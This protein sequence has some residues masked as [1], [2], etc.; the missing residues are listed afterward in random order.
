M[1][2]NQL[3]LILQNMLLTPSSDFYMSS[4]FYS[5]DKQSLDSRIIEHINM[6]VF[7]I[8][9]SEISIEVYDVEVKGCSNAQVR[10][11]AQGAPDIIVDGNVVSFIATHP[12]TQDGYQRPPIRAR[13]DTR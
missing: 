13:A 12:N 10:F 9:G 1:P 6:G 2:D 7:E 11:N 3:V 5:D 4:L 8:L